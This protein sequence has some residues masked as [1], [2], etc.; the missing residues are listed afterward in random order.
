MRP[1][2]CS[3]MT[4]LRTAPAAPLPASAL[5]ISADPHAGAHATGLLARAGL[6][7]TACGGHGEGVL[8]HA[9]VEI[10]VHLGAGGPSARLRAIRRLA[11]LPSVPR[12]VTTMAAGAPNALL[13]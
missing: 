1:E 8:A 2:R 9:G 10:V 4:A 13:R 3:G 7:A 6:A 11:A 5:V 12:L